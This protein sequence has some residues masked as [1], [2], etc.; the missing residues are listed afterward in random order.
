M[1]KRADKYQR[2]RMLRVERRWT[3]LQLALKTKITQ[4]QISMIENGYTDPSAKDCERLAKAFGL[5]V[6]DVFPPE[7]TV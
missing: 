5:P 2:L 4:S 6:E 7:Q 3:Q 1:M